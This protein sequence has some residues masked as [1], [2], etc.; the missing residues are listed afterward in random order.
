MIKIRISC[1]NNVWIKKRSAKN[2]NR[3][4]YFGFLA[5]FFVNHFLRDTTL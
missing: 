2:Q 3:L 1:G 4:F 5:L